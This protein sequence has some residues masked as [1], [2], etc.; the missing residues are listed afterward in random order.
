MWRWRV[1]L[2]TYFAY[3]G[4]YLTRKVFTIAKPVLH[5]E[6]QWDTQSLAHIWTAYL[7]AYMFGQFIC[8]FVGRKWGPRVLLLGGLGLSIV[9]NLIF[10]FTNSYA[11]FLVFMFFNGLVQASG[12]P[13]SVGG[14]AHWLRS[15]ERGFIM[16]FWSSSYLVGN[17]LVKALGARLLGAWGWRWAFWGCTLLSFAIW[18]LIWFWQRTRPSDVGLESIVVDEPDEEPAVEGPRNESITLGEYFRVA[19]NPVVLAMGVGYFCIKFMRYALDSWLPMIL[20]LLGLTAEKAAYCSILFDLAGLIPIMISGWAMDRLFRGRW[21]RL[22][23]LMGVG[24]AL[25]YVAVISCGANPY[26]LALAYG[27]VGFMIYGPDTLL[28]GAASVEV[29]GNQNAVAVAGIVNGL[30]SIGPIFQEEVIGWMMK[31]DSHAGKLAGV[32]N[33][34]L[35]SL[36][37]SLAFTVT[38]AI[39]AWHLA[40]RQHQP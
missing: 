35:M 31:G 14:V 40:R 8:S 16:G 3:V 30:G 12:W 10:G 32:H 7:V 1:L 25:G 27:L 23:C 2:A 17:L 37:I 22:C 6:F 20:T 5:D 34:G 33:V 15:G 21:E 29:A 39:L 4:Y 28:C 18:W 19:L 24:M 26:A 9:F 36:G 13:G 38:M 11:T